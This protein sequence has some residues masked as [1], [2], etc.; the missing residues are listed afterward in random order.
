MKP[1]GLIIAVAVLA[2]LGG[3]TWWSNKK[4]AQASKSTDTTTK[5]LSIPSDQF[6]EIRLKKPAE[7]IDVTGGPGKWR[8]T[9]P[10][11]LPADPDTVGSL[12]TTLGGLNAD[13][14]VEDKASDLTPYGLKEPALDVQIVKKDGKTDDLMIG[15]ETPTGSGNYAKLANDP[16]VFTI[17]TY[18]KNAI[19]K[20]L[21]DLRDKRLLTFDSAKLT[22]V[23]LDA[24]GMPIEFG[25]NSGGDWQ[26]LKPKPWRAD[27]SQ[28][29]TLVNNLKDARMDLTG[30]TKAAATDFASGAKVA[31]ATVTDSSGNQT[32]EIRKK[33]DNYYAKSSAVA[34]IF[35]VSADTGKNF[36][37][38]L[39]DFR[40]KKVYDFG[41]SDP[42]YL[43][44]QGAGYTKNGDKW[45]AGS[46][47]MDNTSVQN[48]I[49]KLRDLTATKVADSGGGTMVLEADVTSS[50]GKRIE[51]VSISKQGDQ[52]FAKRENEPGVYVLDSKAVDD[53]QKAISGIKEAAPAP[54]QAKK[55]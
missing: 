31:T 26:I 13:A 53:L 35:K 29:D 27:G 19:D 42:S 24:K 6:Q 41:F 40:N 25:K 33:G 20:P 12:I 46:K 16:R 21:N 1:N 34:G 54:A 45:M 10:E 39:D 2:V 43:N 14:V 11:A 23:E 52:Y 51:K 55:K 18:N 22:R 3:A 30:D 48:V 7:T 47:T 8:L 15:D 17:A 32:L 44:I 4:Q 37:K 38:G 5:I 36:D 9:Q 50:N 28:V 49:D